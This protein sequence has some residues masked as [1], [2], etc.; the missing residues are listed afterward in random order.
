MKATIIIKF[1][2]YKNTRKHTSHDEPASYYN[3]AK[4]VTPLIRINAPTIVNS[5]KPPY[6]KTANNTTSTTYVPSLP[7][8]NISQRDPDNK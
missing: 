2:K 1:A 7:P 8:L 5:P 6:S 3:V 4:R